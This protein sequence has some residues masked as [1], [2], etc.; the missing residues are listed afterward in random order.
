[1]IDFLFFHR[2][3]VVIFTLLSALRL[4]DSSWWGFWHECRQRNLGVAATAVIAC[5]VDT[6]L[7][8]FG[9]RSDRYVPHLC[10]SLKTY[11]LLRIM[12]DLFP[13][14]FSLLSMFALCSRVDLSSL[15]GIRQ[16]RLS[17][18]HGLMA[19]R[20]CSFLGSVGCRHWR[21]L[22]GRYIWFSKARLAVVNYTVPYMLSKSWVPTQSVA[23]WRSQLEC[24]IPSLDSVCALAPGIFSPYG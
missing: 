5:I 14:L 6:Y 23:S 16:G 11:P 19:F 24:S 8:G 12:T 22:T 2:F 7:G 3:R 10:V 21:I 17:G 4:L 1:M 18:W 20:A 13:K 15:F 9:L